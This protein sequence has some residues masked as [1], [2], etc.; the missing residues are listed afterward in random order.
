[1]K[2]ISAAEAKPTRNFQDQK[3]TIG[4]DLGESDAT[5]GSAHIP[6]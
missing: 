3:L 6:S 5:S 2:K 1:M 4:L